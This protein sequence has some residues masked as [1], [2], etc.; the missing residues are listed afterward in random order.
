VLALLLATTGLAV[1]AR[2]DAKVEMLPGEPPT[3][4]ITTGGQARAAFILP[5]TEAEAVRLVGSDPPP[6]DRMLETLWEEE[7]LA[8]RLLPDADLDARREEFHAY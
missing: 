7:R 6:R 8:E 5:L 2:R 1:A 3:I 4:L